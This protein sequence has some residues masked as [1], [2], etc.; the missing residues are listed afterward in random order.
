MNQPL[1]DL[2]SG[3]PPPRPGPWAG[4][5]LVLPVAAATL[6]VVAFFLG[7]WRA[8]RALRDGA[9]QAA[10]AQRRTCT[11]LLAEQMG[12]KEEALLEDIRALRAERGARQ[13]FAPGPHGQQ[14]TAP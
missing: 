1:Q 2:F 14:G 7:Q 12:L 9:R 13:A 3:K 8:E 11:A 4:A 5:G 6:A 10:E